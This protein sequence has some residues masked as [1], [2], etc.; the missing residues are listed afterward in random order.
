MAICFELVVNFGN[1]TE[2][3]RK[4]ALTDTEPWALRAG[5]HR[6]PLHRP[7][8]STTGPH[9]QLSVLP[10]AVGW[11]VA[12]DGS[13][14][15]FQLSAAE[16]TEPGQQLYGLLATFDGYVAALV[17]WDPESLLDPAELKREWSEELADG[18]LHGLVLCEELHDDLGL[19]DDFVPFRPGYRWLPY[20]GE[21]PSNLT[22][23]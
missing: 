1:N 19:G 18:T 22:A 14:P 4:A 6:I 17:G 10:L 21:K 2:A 8:L 13:L 12:L 11:G 9:I 20:Q 3:A 15:R 7:I 23:E 5:T 16:L